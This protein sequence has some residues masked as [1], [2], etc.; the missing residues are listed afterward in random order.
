MELFYSN[1][2]RDGRAELSAG[3]SKH[4]V[5]VLRH[6]VEDEVLVSGG[7]GNLYRCRIIDAD[8]DRTLLE[9]LSVEGGFGKHDYCLWMAVAPTK[10]V[11]RFE[12]FAEKAVEMGVDRI[13]PL[14]CMHSERKVYNVERGQRLIVAAAKQSL[15]GQV[16]QL[17]VLT[18][19]G[20]LIKAASG[21]PGAK[22]IA[23]CDSDIASGL[24]TRQPL[25]SAV[26][27]LKSSERKPQALFLIGPEG[28]FSSKEIDMALSDGFVPLSLGPS[29]LRTETAA[30]LCTSAVYSAFSCI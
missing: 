7:D 27:S 19:F 25:V 6:R 18:P 13:T 16:P 4:C 2:I 28:D 26:S 15:K 24:N 12:W 9:V 29:R 1:K 23:Y 30:L 20:E 3:E 5:K 8:P 22:F 21:F 11:D 14:L 17:D 10:N